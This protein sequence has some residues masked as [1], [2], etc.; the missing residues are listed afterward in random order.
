MTELNTGGPTYIYRV[1][2]QAIFNNDV[3]VQP[4]GLPQGRLLV[5]TITVRQLLAFGLDKQD[6]L[7]Y[8]NPKESFSCATQS[9]TQYHDVTL[10]YPCRYTTRQSTL[11][12]TFSLFLL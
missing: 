7:S 1:A 12:K 8:E 10:Q 2:L 6:R 5:D 11:H 9:C 4:H 3:R